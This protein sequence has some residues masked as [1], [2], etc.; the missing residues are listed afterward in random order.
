M[1]RLEG[2]PGPRAVPGLD[3][4]LSQLRLAANPL[5]RMGAL[6]KR[7]GAPVAL[8]RGGGGR[9]FSGDPACPGV[10]FVS[11]HR[12]AREVELAHDELHRTALSGQLAPKGPPSS[13]ERAILEWG[14][15]LFAV[16]GDEHRWQRQRIAQFLSRKCVEGYFEEIVRSARRQ[17]R[18]W[19]KDQEIDLHRE[20]MDVTV[21]VSANALLG[22]D[23]DS[24]PGIVRAGAESLRLVLSPA[25][26]LA[27]WDLPGLPYRRFVDAV[28]T[29]NEGMRALVEERRRSGLGS[30]VLSA[31]LRSLGATGELSESEVIGH[32]SVLYAASHE[33]TG[34]ALT[35]TLFLLS[36]HP[37]WHRAAAEEAREALAESEPTLEEVEK[38][39][40]LDWVVKEGLRLIPPAPWTTRIAASEVVIG[41]C[42]V[43]PGTEVVVSI[44]H[45]HRDERIYARPDLF[46]PGRWKHI[47]PDVFQF[48][49]F[50]AG[51]R[52]CVGRNFALLELKT[53]L[54]MVLRNVRLEFKQ[55]QRVDPLLNITLA[56][57]GKLRMVVRRGRQFGRGAGGVKGAIHSLVRL[58][59]ESGLSGG[60]L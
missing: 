22:I 50:S 46:D 52:A 54:A 59:G 60:R 18:A 43:P 34:N 31:L 7:W 36:Q 53:V 29:F 5:R 27:P 13:R 51:P 56:P 48:N 24:C 41:G 12:L 16:N 8:V 6:F 10:V 40:V 11:G 28:Q 23:I 3:P 14:T 38:L 19:G 33:T 21:R 4:M 39:E 44:F 9:V 42:R 25:V 55:G 47:D 37:E 35:W 17:I 57:R 15:G 26:L 1:G 32:A 58:R 30:D 49:A 20:M 45:T 2:I